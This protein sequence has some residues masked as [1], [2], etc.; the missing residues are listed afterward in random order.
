MTNIQWNPSCEATPF[1]SEKWPFKRGGLS[2]ELKS[3]HLCL[4]IHCQVAFP[5]STMGPLFKNL[6]LF[7]LSR[8]FNCWWHNFD[9]KNVLFFI[10]NLIKHICEFC[11][12]RDIWSVM[13]WWLSFVEFDVPGPWL[14]VSIPVWLRTRWRQLA[15]WETLT[16]ETPR[17]MR[18]H[19]HTHDPWTNTWQPWSSYP[20]SPN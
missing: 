14:V 7:K 18:R 16:G 9:F 6:P 4:D 15:A 8:N 12:D 5:E 3:I 2:S 20:R 17:S 19:R 13:F 10:C 1:A 11:N